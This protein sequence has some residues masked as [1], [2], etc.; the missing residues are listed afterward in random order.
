M[1]A[2]DQPVISGDDL[3]RIYARLGFEIREDELEAARERVEA[4]EAGIAALR[5]LDVS[6][7]EPQTVF[8]PGRYP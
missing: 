3:R 7:Y 1:V 5:E 6:G 4:I 2:D 8:S